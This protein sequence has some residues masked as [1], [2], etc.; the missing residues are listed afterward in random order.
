MVSNDFLRRLIN[1]YFAYLFGDRCTIVVMKHLGGITISCKQSN[2]SIEYTV[3]YVFNY[4]GKETADLVGIDVKITDIVN[5][6]ELC[7]IRSMDDYFNNSILQFVSQ[8]IIDND[9]D[10]VY[11]FE[12]VIKGE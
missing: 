5:G 8:M 2:D 9:L 11:K 1:R 6:V 12:C 4:D 7:N 3:D 10:F